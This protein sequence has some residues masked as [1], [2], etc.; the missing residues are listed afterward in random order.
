M[1]GKEEVVRKI[2]ANGIKL[3]CP[4][5]VLTQNSKDSP[6]T[7]S[8]A[9]SLEFDVREGVSARLFST[10][11]ERPRNGID[12]FFKQINETRPG[13]FYPA[14]RYYSLKATDVDG[15]VWTSDHVHVDEEDRETHS[16]VQIKTRQIQMVSPAPEDNDYA[17]LVFVD[18]LDIPENSLTRT[19]TRRGDRATH[20]VDHVG[21]EGEISHATVKFIKSDAN[22][23]QCDVIVRPTEG[24]PALPVNFPSKM[25]ET[26]RF[27][28][29]DMIF[30]AMA[31]TVHSGVRKVVFAQTAPLNSGISF[32][33][34][35]PRR[36]HAPDFYRLMDRYLSY[37]Y[38]NSS[39][40]DFSFISTKLHPLYNLKYVS[41]EAV[42]LLV[43]VTVES[44]IQH[45]FKTVGSVSQAVKNEIEEIAKAIDA[46]SVSDKIKTRAKSSLGGMKSLRPVDRLYALQS[47]NKILVGEIQGWK[48]LRNVSAHGSLRMEPGPNQKLLDDIFGAANLLNKLIFLV[49]GYSGVYT[50]YSTRGWPDIIFN[51]V[52]AVEAPTTVSEAV[53]ELEQVEHKLV[54]PVVRPALPRRLLDALGRIFHWWRPKT[55]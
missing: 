13:E 36:D 4:K 24:G 3:D 27:L 18:K 48:D 30:F 15:N 47:E 34:I 54:A 50:D 39:G 17:H 33:P 43:S 29:G 26:L 2:V 19:D 53:V 42:A 12:E 31:E 8:F 41:L 11:P 7:W 21:S 10:S 6:R 9:G 35:A 14:H 52:A 22:P 38:A 55:N 32:R 20:K 44:V 46:L 16:I 1:L 23:S 51:P 28:T 5:I 40:D 49:V 45:S 25:I 37:A